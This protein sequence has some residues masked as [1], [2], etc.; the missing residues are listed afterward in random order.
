M[1]S[2]AAAVR[3]A[4]V[5]VPL[6]AAFFAGD[7]SQGRGAVR[8]LRAEAPKQ[9]KSFSA[10]DVTMRR[11]VGQ[12]GITAVTDWVYSGAGVNPFS[13]A[14]PKR[15][16]EDTAPIRLFQGNLD[17]AT[18]QAAGEDIRVLL[19]EY[20]SSVVDVA[21]RE[22]AAQRKLLA[23]A[24]NG[25]FVKLLGTLDDSVFC[26]TGDVDE[27]FEE[28][29]RANL[30]VAAPRRGSKWLVYQWSGLTTASALCAP[31]GS[32]SLLKAT[33]S[34]KTA[35]FPMGLKR[36]AE[37]RQAYVAAVMQG[38]LRATAALHDDCRMAHRSL[39][40][41][42][43]TLDS[44]LHDKTTVFVRSTLRV[45]LGNFG[46]STPATLGLIAEDLMQLGFALLALLLSPAFYNFS[47]SGAPPAVDE[48]TLQRL[49]NEVMR[50]DADELR[51]FV[52]AEPAWRDAD[53]WLSR[54]DG[55]GWRALTS[56]L[57]ATSQDF[58]EDPSR[59]VSAAKLLRA[60]S[61][62]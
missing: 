53:A 17:D 56:M 15:T 44:N 23:N 24:P 27:R 3:L 55:A 2:S 8:P 20:D 46:Y 16:R 34:A 52:R 37:V 42:S 1:A 5:C 59:L 38:A 7:A 60:F 12:I 57:D 54:G 32:N 31:V 50:G 13:S 36:K 11:F 48:E 33:E 35:F 18:R 19:R 10:A 29:W 49:Y 51:Q 43:I 14:Q 58:G 26:G 4:L 39:G 62:T 41:A 30:G 25:A 28:A 9:L 6:A 22:I 21:D 47:E 45:R 61:F 40:L